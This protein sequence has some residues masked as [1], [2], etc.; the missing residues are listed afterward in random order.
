MD[1]G[2]GSI[3]FKSKYEDNHVRDKLCWIVSKSD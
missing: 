1:A 3:I 2:Y